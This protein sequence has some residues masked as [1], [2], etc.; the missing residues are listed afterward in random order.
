MGN[1][2]PDE[3]EERG[4]H[5]LFGTM[6]NTELRVAAVEASERQDSDNNVN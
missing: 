5:G 1:W 3:L 2:V 4:E 6:V